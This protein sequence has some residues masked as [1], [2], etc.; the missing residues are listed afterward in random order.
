MRYAEA[1]DLAGR[2]FD[3]RGRFVDVVAVGV[4]GDEGAENW[5]VVAVRDEGPGSIIERYCAEL[6]GVVE[7]PL[8]DGG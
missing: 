6:S 2:V 1:L 7:A 8:G 4:V 5:R 3:D